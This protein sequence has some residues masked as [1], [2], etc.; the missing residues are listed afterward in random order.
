M[1]AEDSRKNAMYV[2]KVDFLD[3]FCLSQAVNFATQK[4]PKPLVYVD[5]YRIYL[6]FALCQRH[7]QLMSDKIKRTWAN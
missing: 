3:R 1:E 4:A 7:E 5:F 6:R 2:V